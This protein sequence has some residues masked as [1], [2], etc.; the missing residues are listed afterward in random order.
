VR[1][2]ATRAAAGLMLAGLAAAGA[3]AE[4]MAT[5]LDALGHAWAKVYYGTPE[6]RQ[7]VDY[8]PLVA[9]AEA[10]AATYPGKAEPLIWEAIVL[11]SYAKA[12]GGLGALD[13]AERAR[14]AALAAAKIDE[15][16]LDAGADTALGVLYYK[17]PGWPLGFGNDRLAQHYLDKALAIAPAAVDVNYF[18]GDFMIE[19]G[20]KKKA[21]AFLE[22]ALRAPPRPGRADADAGRKIEIRKDL[23]KLGG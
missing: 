22:K 9:T 21:R 20:D 15:K 2:I 1:S 18:Y 6:S 4:D 16:A 5:R 14:D 13:L 12:K 23:A 17:V 11:S 19:Q 8:P 3:K 10:I 7:A